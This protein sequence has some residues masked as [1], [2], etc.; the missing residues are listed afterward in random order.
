M[1]FHLAGPTVM[2]FQMESHL[3]FLTTTAG[4][5]EQDL[6]LLKMMAFQKACH[7]VE[8][9][10][11]ARLRVYHLVGHDTDG[12]LEGISLGWLDVDGTLEGASLG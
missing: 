7:S 10:Q 8:L 4:W 12:W 5:R 3:A 1:A 11:T 9:I 2:E 6:A